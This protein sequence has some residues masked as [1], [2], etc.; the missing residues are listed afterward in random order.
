MHFSFAHNEISV[1]YFIDTKAA[2]TGNIVYYE[3][4]FT[5][6]KSVYHQHEACFAWS[7]LNLALCTQILDA[8]THERVHRDMGATRA[9][10]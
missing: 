7:L 9:L 2:F 5:N 1:L 8:L 4:L 3:M 6:S 10:A